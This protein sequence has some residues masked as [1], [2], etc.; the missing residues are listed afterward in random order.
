M[1]RNN[2]IIVFTAFAF[3]ALFYIPLFARFLHPINLFSSILGFYYFISLII[4]DALLTITGLIAIIIIVY[5]IVRKQVQNRIFLFLAAS[6]LSMVFF[7]FQNVFIYKIILGELPIGSN[8]VKFDPNQWKEKSSLNAP[9][10]ISYRERMLKNLVRSV[11]PGKNRGE[12]VE[13]LGPSLETNYFKDVDKDLIYF[14]GPERTSIFNI[15]SEWLLIWIDEDGKFKKYQ[16]V[17]D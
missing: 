11:L 4:V 7:S 8:L 14:L 5:K 15:D 3:M 17:N 13:L 10:G 16:I 2:L 1:K 12:I 6:F 9:G